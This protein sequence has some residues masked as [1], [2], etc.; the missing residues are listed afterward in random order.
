MKI[1]L[2][3]GGKASPLSLPINILQIWP[4]VLSVATKQP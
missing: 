4:K 1:V 3:L 2:Q